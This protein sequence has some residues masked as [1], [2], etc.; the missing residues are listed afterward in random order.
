MDCICHGYGYFICCFNLG[1]YI[2]ECTKIIDN[3]K[4]KKR[5][6]MIKTYTES[7]FIGEDQYIKRTVSFLG[8][9]VKINL[10]K[11]IKKPELESSRFFVKLKDLAF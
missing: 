7:Y 3:R 5:T 2:F 10:L 6:Q 9:P 4:N 8:I 11:G 1:N